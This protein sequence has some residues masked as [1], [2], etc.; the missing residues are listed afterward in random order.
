ML[1]ADGAELRITKVYGSPQTRSEECTVMDLPGR[2]QL[3]EGAKTVGEL[4]SLS[5]ASQ[6]SVSQFLGRMKS[7]GIVN[8]KRE[9]QF[10]YYEIANPDLKKLVRSMHSIFCGVR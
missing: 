8:S 5:G 6:S 2:C 7:E 4:E 1:E 9:G 3:T 10:T